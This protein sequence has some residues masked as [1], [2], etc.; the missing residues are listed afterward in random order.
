METLP[1]EVL[2][3]IFQLM[4]GCDL[5]T[6]FYV[7][8]RWAQIIRNT[9]RIWTGNF[10][11]KAIGQ[12]MKNKLCRHLKLFKFVRF[13]DISESCDK[14]ERIL[15]AMKKR[16]KF[17]QV[18]RLRDPDHLILDIS[19]ILE[20]PA[21]E[22]L[23]IVFHELKKRQERLQ[24]LKKQFNVIP[25]PY[26]WRFINELTFVWRRGVKSHFIIHQD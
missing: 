4:S 16:R 1:D 18:I 25:L 21:L 5:E 9:P 10:P 14:S 12:G 17:L 26:D 8:P 13:L 19:T 7:C 20:F 3:E 23:H 15:A 22:E 24:M 11:F 2:I 6:C